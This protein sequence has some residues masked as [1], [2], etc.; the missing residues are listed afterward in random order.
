MEMGL[1][2]HG[3]PSPDLNAGVGVG[4]GPLREK[5]YFRLGEGSRG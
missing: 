3:T 1:P 2:I 4:E 5:P